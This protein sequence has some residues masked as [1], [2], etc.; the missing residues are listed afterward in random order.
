MP[1]GATL[2]FPGMVAFAEARKRDD[3]LGGPQKP[4]EKPTPVQ[5]M[6]MAPGSFSGLISPGNIDL[7]K[8]PKVKNPDGSISTVRSIGINMDGKA[9]VIPTVAHDGSRILSD[10]EAIEQYRKTGKY[11]GVFKSDADADA[12][13][14]ALHEAYAAGKIPGYEPSQK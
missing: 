4:S 3:S 2:K 14:K 8:Q 6:M 11:L 5:G 1:V 10:K 7:T 12:Y 13:A 9:I